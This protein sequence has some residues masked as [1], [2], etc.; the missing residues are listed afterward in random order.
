MLKQAC[1]L[2]KVVGALVIIGAIN[3]GLIAVAGFNLVDY[4]FG[5]GT[6]ASRIVYGLVGLSGLALFGSYFTSCRACKKG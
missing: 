1:V 6:V 3:W 5:V 2:C 4:I